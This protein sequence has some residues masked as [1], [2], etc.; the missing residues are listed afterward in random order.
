MSDSYISLLPP[1][2]PYLDREIKAAGDE[3]SS[4]S[5]LSER[6]A[7]KKEKKKERKKE[8]QTIVCNHCSLRIY[9]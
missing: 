4:T 2:T 9:T 3:L 6:G 7:G 1:A 5:V 8:S